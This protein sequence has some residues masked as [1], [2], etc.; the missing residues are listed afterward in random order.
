MSL[1]LCQQ[2]NT[3][4]TSRPHSCAWRLLLS[5]LTMIQPSL[6]VTGT[7]TVLFLGIL[8][9][10]TED[11]PLLGIL[12]F[13]IEDIPIIKSRNLLKWLHWRGLVMKSAT[14][15]LVGHH[16]IS[17]SFMLTLSVMKKYHLLI[18]LV[19]LP[20]DALPFLSNRMELILSFSKRFWVTPFPWAIR[21]Y[22]LVWCKPG[23]GWVKNS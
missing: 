23:S 5:S 10:L 20:L 16:S 22:Q 1:L 21:M 12:A 7:V 13:L 6:L 4:R 14:I 8:A 9:F 19:C 2:P 18:C 17:I 11:I 3:G 15:S